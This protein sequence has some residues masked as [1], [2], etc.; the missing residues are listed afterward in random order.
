MNVFQF[1]NGAQTIHASLLKKLQILQCV[2][3]LFETP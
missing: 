2:P 3:Y 1:I